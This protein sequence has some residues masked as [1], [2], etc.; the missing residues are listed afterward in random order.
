MPLLNHLGELNVISDSPFDFLING[1]LKEESSKCDIKI[2]N[3]KST[4]LSIFCTEKVQ[5]H[6]NANIYM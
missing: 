6:I 2:L 1:I 4:K 5:K 3:I